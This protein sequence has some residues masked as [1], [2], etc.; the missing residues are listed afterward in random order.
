[1]DDFNWI[2]TSQ[3]ARLVSEEER[4]K[5]ESQLLIDESKKRK[6][7]VEAQKNWDRFYK[8]NTDKQFKDRNWTKRDLQEIL[9]EVDFNTSLVF[10][11]AGCGVGN[12]LLP[13]KSF[14]PHW[15]ICGF[16]FS[17]NAIQI[18]DEKTKELNLQV[19]SAVI[20]L[21]SSDVENLQTT[22]RFPL[23]DII[24]LIFVLSSISP[25]KQALVVKNLKY[26]LKPGEVL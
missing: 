14:F 8:R 5:L 26:Y 15:T 11:E 18:L 6:F 22:V 9:D 2:K 25:E 1:M 12:T 20:D 16:D 10:L 3:N 23:A 17:K 13:M 24:S 21:T 7:E 4:N 19:Q